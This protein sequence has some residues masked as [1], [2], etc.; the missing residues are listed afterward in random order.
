MTWVRIDDGFFQHPKAV[1]A[2]PAGRALFLAACCW[3]SANLT[4][5]HIPDEVLPLLSAQSGSPRTTASRLE[6]V[7]LWHRN[8]DGWVIHDFLTYNLSRDK[9]H[10]RREAWRKRQR[11]ARGSDGT[12]GDVT[13]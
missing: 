8:G 7:G 12:E 13:P 5:G 9:A 2:G 3:A 11:R 6:A 4:D 1:A 10:A